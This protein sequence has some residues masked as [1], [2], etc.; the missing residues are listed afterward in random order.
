[1][2]MGYDFKKLAVSWL[3]KIKGTASRHFKVE[4]A[5]KT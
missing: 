1:M 5:L 3:S 2:P 4:A